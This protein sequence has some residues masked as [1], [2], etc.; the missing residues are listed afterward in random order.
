MTSPSAAMKLRFVNHASFICEY[1]GTRVLVDPWLFGSA[2]N[3]GWSLLCETRLSPEE[4]AGVDYI[5]FSHEHPDHF[6]PRALL[7]IPREARAKITV[8]YQETRDGKVLEFCRKQGFATR[9]LRDRERLA[10][11]P[12]F[13]ATCQ[14]VPIY[15]SWLMLETPQQRLLDLN[16]APVHTERALARLARLGPIDVLLTQFGYAG[17]RGNEEDTALRRSDADKKLALVR[18]QVRQLRPRF[19]VPF[20]SY[21]YYS[22]EE[23]GFMNDALNPP[24][25]AAAA[26]EEG[27]SVP[28]VLY[29][30]DR[31]EVGA[32]HDSGPALA[33]YAEAFASIPAREPARSPSISF[34]ELAEAAVGYRQRIRDNND[35]TTMA[36]LRANPVLPALRPVEIHLWDLGLDVRFSFEHGLERLESRTADYQ[37]SMASSSLR[38][39]FA[40]RWGAD[41]LAVNARFRADA[42]GVRRLLTTFGV[43]QLNNVGIRIS[44]RFLLD[45]GSMSFLLRALGRKLWSLRAQGEAGRYPSW[46]EEAPADD[47]S[48]TI[49]R[50]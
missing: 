38:F 25:R 37:L 42:G 15:D 46:A 43:D 14:A 3:E 35:R 12:G 29:P 39:I 33:R 31:W 27:G 24:D 50:R 40:H 41:T 48:S 9:P 34:E 49:A 30:D 44:P 47:A 28:V 20:A 17:W 26:I 7:S 4:L 21:V 18:R 16:D 5:W 1:A 36:L 13:F 23:N 32:E 8:L 10:L 19:T 22:H 11:A 6:S 45:F 2:F